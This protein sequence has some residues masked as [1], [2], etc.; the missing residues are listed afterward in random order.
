M[1]A[2]DRAHL[3]HV[4][5][6]RDVDRA[7][8]AEH[9]EDWLPGEI[10]DAHVHV[11]DPALQL[12]KPSEAKRRSYWVMEVNEPQ[13]AESLARCYGIV[14]PNRKVVL[15][16]FGHPDL[17]FDTDGANAYTSQQCEAR[18]WHGLAVSRP[19]WTAA[20]TERVLN[21][22][23]IIG[24]KPYY[25]M[26]GKSEAT[27]DTH[28]AASIFD[29]LPHHQLEVL[30]ARGGWLTLHVP[31]AERLGHPDNIREVKEIRRRYPDIVLVIAH[32]G[33]SYTEPHAQEA[34]PLLADDKGL[35]WDNCAV[36]NPAV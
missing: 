32:L 25:G 10:L 14:F 11:T 29:F 23:G 2:T 24:L 31:K 19:Q 20:E 13:S 8:W 36:L 1:D 30:N 28:I 21:L 7:F 4:F 15:L 5:D 34:I 6:Y 33:R 26:I 22:P 16:C 3:H 18:G 17:A 27:R 35:Y 12:E 9:L